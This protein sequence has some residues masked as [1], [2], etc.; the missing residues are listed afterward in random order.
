MLGPSQL[1][2]GSC[3]H[4]CIVVGLTETGKYQTLV[5]V[6]SELE[7]TTFETETRV[8]P[9]VLGILELVISKSILP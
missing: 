4:T 3:A 6:S 5:L 9:D 1:S 8:G 7:N 2:K